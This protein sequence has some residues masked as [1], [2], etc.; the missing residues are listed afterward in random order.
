MILLC[1]VSGISA[2]SDDVVDDVISEVD[3]GDESISVINEEQVISVDNSSAL[4][5]QEK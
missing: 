1:C 4:V 5:A 3:S 2:V